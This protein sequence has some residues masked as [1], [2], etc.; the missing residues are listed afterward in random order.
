MRIGCQIGIWKE[1]DFEAKM[2]ASGAT[3]VRG[4]EV[5]ASQLKPYHED[6]DGLKALLEGAGLVLSGAYFNS[7][8]FVDPAA[9][10]AVVAEAAADCDFLGRV[11]GGFLVVNGGVS[12]GDSG[13]T[14]SDDEFRRL[15]DVLNR[16][17]DAAAER[18]V[19]AVMHPHQKCQVETPGDVDRLVASG[20]DWERV[21]LCVHASHQFNIGADPYAIYEKHA[22]RVRYAHIGNA[23]SDRKGALLGEGALDQKRLMRPLLDAGFDGWVIIECGK[24]GVG[25]ADYVADAVEYLEAT[26]PD[27]E[28]RG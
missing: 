27:V 11:G 16:I 4:F 7:D 24:A 23:T 26:W 12:K 17:G 25:A 1:G 10:D 21:G 5:F 18:G 2:A 28:W 13:R 15:A 19:E 14:F 9:G 8:G 6:P 20:L 3:G 22:A